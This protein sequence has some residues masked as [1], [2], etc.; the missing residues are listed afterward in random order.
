MLYHENLRII[1]I[2]IHFHRRKNWKM[3]AVGFTQEEFI[4]TSRNHPFFEVKCGQPV[5]SRKTLCQLE[6]GKNIQEESLYRFFLSKLGMQYAYSIQ[7]ERMYSRLFQR[8]DE[9][10]CFGDILELDH[11]KPIPNE[12]RN[13][14]YD[15]YGQ[16]YSSTR[17]F[18]LEAQLPSSDLLIDV[19]ELWTIVPARLKPLLRF[20]LLVSNTLRRDVCRREIRLVLDFTSKHPIDLWIDAIYAVS[21]GRIVFCESLLKRIK[22]TH[23]SSQWITYL[24]HQLR[25]FVI[26]SQQARP[27]EE[28]ASI[29]PTLPIFKLGTRILLGRLGND[30]VKRQDFKLAKV[31]LNPISDPCDML[32]LRASIFLRKPVVLIEMKDT[33]R[34]TS[35][36]VRYLSMDIETQAHDK[37]EYLMSHLL[38]I[39]EPQDRFLK[40]CLFRDLQYLVT[41]T[42]KYKCLHE[43]AEFLQLTHEPVED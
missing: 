39:V 15:F 18:Y 31:Y 42:R 4:L 43:C 30:A 20:I 34:R 40:T 17:R 13:V 26:V 16:L 29:P 19:L 32:G 38:P 23:S 41:H 3:H 10:L 7:Q 11:L 5:C 1:G 2:L 24:A 25:T 35:I 8:F 36:L 9:I 22:S 27:L 6:K 12:H 14:I 28:V 21:T 33:T 37:L